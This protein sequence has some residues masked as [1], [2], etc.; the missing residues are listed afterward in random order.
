MAH[1]TKWDEE[2][3]DAIMSGQGDWFSAQLLR[4]CGKADKA[5]LEQI[6]AGFP[7]HVQLWEKWYYKDDYYAHVGAMLHAVP[8]RDD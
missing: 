3:I 4:M 8:S 6:R 1:I 7:D 2:N 5:T